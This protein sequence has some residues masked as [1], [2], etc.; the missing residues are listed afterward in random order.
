MVRLIILFTI[1]ATI[2]IS[3]FQPQMHKP[4]IVY[5]SEYK[6][7]T[8]T[9][10]NE[11]SPVD[12]NIAIAEKEVKSA[13]SVTVKT[14]KIEQ[15]A[16]KIPD[17]VKITKD[18]TTQQKPKVATKKIETKVVPTVKKEEKK[19]DNNI[20]TIIDKY[21]NKPITAKE[22]ETVKKETPK[23]VKQVEKKV[24]QP[25]VVQEQKT[26]QPQV[27]QSVHIPA[28]QPTKTAEQKARE[29][30][31]AWN[32]W[33][34]RLQ[35]Q[36]MEDVNMPN[37]PYGTIFKF[38]FTVDKYGK[39]SR[40]QTWS[41]NPAYTPHAIQY[42]APV[43]RSYQGRAILNF[44]AGSNRVTTDVAGAWKVSTKS[45]YSTPQDYNDTERVIK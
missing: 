31:I 36:I 39:I 22:Q 2:C 13:P 3:Y 23:A 5:N 37:I 41:S 34:S 20:K 16:K 33:R 30:E 42:I 28:I 1:I 11:A 43:I 19:V 8:Q 27:Q 44:P 29:E 38:T 10:S 21:S 26:T 4:L 25:K 14:E 7:V 45:K 32:K 17:I 18:I 12:D 9:Q 40:V 24:E 15:P 6:L 35:N